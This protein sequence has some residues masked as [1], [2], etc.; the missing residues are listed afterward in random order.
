MAMK[1]KVR[2][3]LGVNLRASLHIREVERYFEALNV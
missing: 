1:S 3:H 2:S